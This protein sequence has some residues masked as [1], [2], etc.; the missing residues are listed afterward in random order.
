MSRM[1]ML[2]APG[3]T[4]NLMRWL[5]P[6]VQAMCCSDCAAAMQLTREFVASVQ[7]SN[8]HLFDSAFE[9]ICWISVTRSAVLQHAAFRPYR[10]PSMVLEL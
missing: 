2:Q 10:C 9:S 4:Q 6:L 7:T 8:R 3:L 1:R 5:C